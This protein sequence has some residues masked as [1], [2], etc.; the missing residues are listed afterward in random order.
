MHFKQDGIPSGFWRIHLLFI[1]NNMPL[2]RGWRKR[3]FAPPPEW[4][5]VRRGADLIMRAFVLLRQNLVD[6]QDLV[7]RIKTIEMEMKR[8]LKEIYEILNA[9]L[10]PSIKRKAIGFRRSHERSEAE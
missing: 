2:L 9:L 3:V 10:N 1:P 7:Q 8:N 4:G 6:Y 5:E